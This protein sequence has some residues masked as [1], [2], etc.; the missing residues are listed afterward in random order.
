MPTPAG[1]HFL[2]IPGPSNVP[3]RVLRAID[4]PTIDH[5]G[6]EFQ[7]LGLAV[8]GGLKTIFRT[9][10]PVIMFPASGT[11]GWEAALVNTLSA[12]DK[13]LMYETGHFASLWKA[14]AER[15]GLVPEFL[16][17]GDDSWRRGADPAAIEARLAS[18]RKHEIKAVCVVH[19]ETSTGVTSHID[20]VRKA[21]DRAGH[22]ALLMVDTISGLGSIDYRHDE[23]GVD[24]TIAG[25]QKGM[26]LPPGLSFNAVSPK[27]LEAAKASKLPK[28]FWSWQEMLGPNRNGFF[29]YTPSTN[30]MYGLREAIAMMHEEGLDNVFARHQR[31]AEATRRAVRAWGLEIQCLNED[32]HSPVLTA[33]RMP[34]GHDEASFRKVVLQHFDMS[35]GSGLGKVTGKVFRIGHLGDFNDLT[36]VGTLA[37]VGMG[38]E[39]A[40]IPHDKGG[41]TAA[42]NYLAEAHKAAPAG[43]FV[44]RS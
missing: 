28:S 20:Q 31:H 26:M 25:S 43:T 38:L 35:L 8:L 41:V 13:V 44:T 37:G 33:V 40:G 5:R 24:V 32:E 39:L 2:Q 19:N 18:D 3:D 29:P 27:A 7:Q 4:R 36:L 16:A 12:G 9:E 6:P 21:I 42:M 22:P 11:G 34:E 17:V 23:W 1:R 14:I 15:L 10:H 30:L